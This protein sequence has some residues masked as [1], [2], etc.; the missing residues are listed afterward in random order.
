MMDH[1][2]TPPRLP[3][4]FGRVPSDEVLIAVRHLLS[5]AVPKLSEEP[6]PEKR[7][8]AALSTPSHVPIKG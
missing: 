5:H 2:R 1:V 6:V 7:L 3:G 4:T 8:G